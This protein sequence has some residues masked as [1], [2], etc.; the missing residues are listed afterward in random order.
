ME[1]IPRPNGRRATLAIQFFWVLFGAFAALQLTNAYVYL[2][3]S[4]TLKGGFD[5]GT[6]LLAIIGLVWFILYIVAIVLFL[7]W[8]RR[9]YKNLERMGILIEHADGWAS[10]GWFVPILNLFRPYEIMIEIWFKT[11]RNIPNNNDIKSTLIINYW[12]GLFI[13]GNILGRLFSY[14]SGED[15]FQMLAIFSLIVMV[16]TLTAL[17]LIIR[18]IQQ[19]SEFEDRLYRSRAYE[20]DISEH[21]IG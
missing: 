12:W 9:A 2:V 19:V 13:G 5:T 20:V 1:T 8:F 18:I 21:L 17:F 4:G 14:I 6:T 10:G 3:F 15:N 16:I 7:Q 11:Q